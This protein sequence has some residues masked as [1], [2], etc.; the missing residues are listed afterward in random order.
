MP[1]YTVFI[2][3]RSGGLIYSAQFQGSQVHPLNECLRLASTLHSVQQISRQVS[4]VDILDDIGL[5]S[6]EAKT[7]RLRLYQPLTGIQ[8]VAI[9]TP[10]VTDEILLGILRRLHLLYADYALKNPFYVQDM[11]IRCKLFDIHFMK[12]MKPYIANPV[13]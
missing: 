5:T 1:I 3:N 4:P 6:L 10:E 13:E 7:F 8:F 12:L 2:I 9:A 11:P